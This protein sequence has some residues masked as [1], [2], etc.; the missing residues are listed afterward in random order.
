MKKITSL[1]LAAM[2]ATAVAPSAFARGDGWEQLKRHEAKIAELKAEKYGEKKGEKKGE[3]ASKQKPSEPKK[4]AL[5][6][7]G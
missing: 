3:Q 6:I 4:T 5:E 2:L 1:L 7:D